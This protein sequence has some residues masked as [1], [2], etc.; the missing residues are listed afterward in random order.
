MDAVIHEGGGGKP[1]VTRK[2]E[3]AYYQEVTAKGCRKPEHTGHQPVCVSVDESFVKIKIVF[4]T[5]SW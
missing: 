4:S 1:N 5:I 3:V 2:Q